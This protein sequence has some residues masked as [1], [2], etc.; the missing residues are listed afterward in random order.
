[1]NTPQAMAAAKPVIAYDCDG[2]REV[3]LE[4]E[5]GFLVRAGETRT[6]TNK[7]LQVAGDPALRQRLGFAGQTMV[8]KFF[9]VERMVEQIH[10]LYLELLTAG[11]RQ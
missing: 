2:A 11:G 4:N 7:L 10:E 9:P 5:T 8:R 6:L 3:C 1:M